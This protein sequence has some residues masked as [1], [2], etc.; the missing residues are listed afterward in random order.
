M[1][2]EKPSSNSKQSEPNIRKKSRMAGFRN[3]NLKFYEFD[4]TEKAQKLAAKYNYKEYMVE[5]YF[6]MFNENEVEE[7]LSVNETPSR[8]HIRINKLK[9]DTKTT[10]ESLKKKKYLLEK[11]EYSDDVFELQD[12]ESSEDNKEKIT[13][14]IKK[15]KLNAKTDDDPDFSR[16]QKTLDSLEWGS[17][18]INEKERTKVVLDTDERKKIKKKHTSYIGTLGSTNE[19]LMGHY[20]IQG[21]APSL[22]AF[23]LH[24]LESDIVVDMCASPGGK[25]I[26]LAQIMNNK[27]RI[28]ATE[29][30]QERIKALL[31][32]LR[33]CGVKNTTVLN[34][35]ANT[36]TKNRI[37]PDKILLDAPCSGEGLIRIDVTRKHSK[38]PADIKRLMLIQNR[39]L[40]TAIKAVKPGGLVMYSTCSIAPEENEFIIQNILDHNPNIEITDIDDDLG[41]PG[42]TEVFGVKLSDDFLKARRFFPHIHDTIGFFLCLLKKKKSDVKK[43]R[44]G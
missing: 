2:E 3:P 7:F 12:S 9:A 44:K 21:K 42:Y 43:I 16:D 39:L 31:F 6:R 26:Q 22:P 15:P 18:E 33:R 20:Y 25:T 32:N 37:K 38:K 30:N 28:I 24:P 29:I 10:I 4:I 36:I 17:P 41:L 8:I 23:Y 13:Q 34:I 11:V 27:G 40:K 19:Y 5:R 14:K 1:S 35:D